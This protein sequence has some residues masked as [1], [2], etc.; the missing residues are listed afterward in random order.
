METPAMQ[1]L[2][3]FLRIC[4]GYFTLISLVVSIFMVRTLYWLYQHPQA[5]KWRT[6]SNRHLTSIAFLALSY[7]VRLIPL[8]M[9]IIYG[10]AW[11]TLK[12]GRR[13]ARTW[14]I[15]ASIVVLLS[16][17]GLIAARF[18]LF[19]GGRHHLRVSFLIFQIFFFSIGILGLIVFTRTSSDSI[20][21][22]GQR[23]RTQ[24]DG[25]SAILD[26]IVSA[27]ALAGVWGGIIFYSRW[28]HAQDLPFVRGSVAWPV[29][30]LVIFITIALHEAAH[31]CV[32]L[33]LGMKLRAIAIGPFQ[34]R[35]RDGR[36]RYRFV[37]AG[38]LSFGGS[39]GIVPTRPDQSRWVEVAMIAAGPLINF[40]AALIA[41]FLTFSAKGQPWERHWE[42]IAFFALVN[43]V[44]F[45]INLV[46]FRPEALYSD[47][48]RIFQ[49]LSGGPWA[50][51][52]R[53]FSMVAS[54]T[55]TPLRPRN[56]DI[57]AIR[58][59]AAHFTHGREALMLR[60]FATSY[61]ID[62]NH[63][64]EAGASFAEAAAILQHDQIN[65]PS[66]LLTTFVFNA[67]Y[68]QRDAATARRY[69][70]LFESKAP[71][72]FGV[73]YWLSRSALHLIENH[74]L[75]ARDAWNAGAALARKLPCAGA[76]EFDRDRYRMMRS[77]LNTASSADPEPSVS[78]AKLLRMPAR[79]SAPR[80]VPSRTLPGGNFTA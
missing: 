45:A 76:Y 26:L 58:S 15:S 41:A 57:A 50:E 20:Q 16:T 62:Q 5:N 28:G 79:D 53:V 61:Y 77:L 29:I 11:W 31:A 3:V 17:T 68:L 48:A 37:P 10:S 40:V 38:I 74:P 39:T 49:L 14:T 46:P 54:G 51:L 19:S 56:Y 78:S 42:P 36:W 23:N 7:F 30:L 73:D 70:D 72:H 25:T 80:T 64:P 43:V 47:G 9:A 6:N 32:G 35:I 55:V 13:S 27:L 71:T 4:F 33:A 8:L 67:V 24:G 12:H 21:S 34:W 22:S 2:R 65:V 75:E 44:T 1:R 52:H 63:F 69:W 18:L 59:A 66:D 60:L